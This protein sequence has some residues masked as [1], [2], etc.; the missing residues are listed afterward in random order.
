MWGQLDSMGKIICY[1]AN[2]DNMLINL[3]TPS[4]IMYK[5]R[6]ESVIDLTLPIFVADVMLGMNQKRNRYGFD[7][8]F[9]GKEW[10]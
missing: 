7:P 9:N 4:Q 3:F 1:R 10:M 6:K 8:F 5:F 2:R